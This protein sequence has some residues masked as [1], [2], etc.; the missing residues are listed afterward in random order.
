MGG[1]FAGAG[2]GTGRSVGQ[3]NTQR[4]GLS[5]FNL[6]W[7]GVWT[8]QSRI[9]DRGW[10]TEIA[11]PFKTLRYHPGEEQNWGLNIMRN[12]RRK[13]EQSFWAPVSRADTIQRVS[14][15]GDMTISPPQVRN[16]QYHSLCSGGDTEELRGKRAG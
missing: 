11:I 15:A 14:V 10:E 12:I 13:N 16:L 7:D 8:V 2:S 3:G 6:N 1:R 4:G 9:T 5:G